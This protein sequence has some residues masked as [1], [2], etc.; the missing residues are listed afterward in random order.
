MILSVRLAALTDL[1][2][3]YD[4]YENQRLGLGEEFLAA[5][6]TSAMR[7]MTVESTAMSTLSALVAWPTEST[8]QCRAN[9]VRLRNHI[10]SV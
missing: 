9:L 2:D 8:G 7:H 3:A 6:D 1:S 5:I 4:W 10:S